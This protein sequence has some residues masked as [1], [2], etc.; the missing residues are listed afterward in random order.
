ML[1]QS[2]AVSVDGNLDDAAR[3]AQARFPGNIAAHTT[4]DHSQR[5][6]T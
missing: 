5:M 6:R 1:G 4:E 3:Q 2:G